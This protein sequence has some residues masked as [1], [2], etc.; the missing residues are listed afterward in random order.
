MMASGP[1][2][3]LGIG[4]EY[5]PYHQLSF[6]VQNLSDSAGEGED[7]IVASL[8][9]P[10][11]GTRQMAL[12]VLEEWLKDDYVPSNAVKYA[13]WHLKEAEPSDDIKALLEKIDI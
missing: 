8:N 11:N 5:R 12:S 3:N 6:L 4:E 13:V 9:S 1:K 2:D 7:F 10:V